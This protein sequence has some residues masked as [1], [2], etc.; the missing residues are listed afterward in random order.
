[1]LRINTQGDAHYAGVQ[2]CGSMRTPQEFRA[3]LHGR[4]TPFGR[5]WFDLMKLNPIGHPTEISDYVVKTAYA[6][7]SGAAQ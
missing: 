2:T 3:R 6:V 4:W 7:V 5:A 1:M